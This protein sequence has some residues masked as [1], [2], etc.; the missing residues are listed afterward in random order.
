M[1]PSNATAADYEEVL[2]LA[3]IAIRE[4]DKFEARRLARRASRLEP[5]KEEPWLILAGL[6][7]PRPGLAYAARALEI[8]P[9]SKAAKKA[10]RWH[11][12]RLPP[13]EREEALKEAHIPEDLI[14]EIL[15][16]EA[17]AQNK[18]FSNRVIVSAAVIVVSLG[19][20]VGGF[21]ADALQPKASRDPLAKAT[22]TPTPTPTPTATPTP[23]PTSTPTQT[24]T[25]TPTRTPPVLSYLASYNIPEDELASEGRWIDVDLSEQ[26]VH[27]YEGDELVRS[28]TVSTGTS[29]HPT[30]TGQYRVYI[31]LT[32]TAM[33][34]PGYYL[35]GVPYTMYFY[36][37]YALHGTYWHDNFGVP[38]SHGCINMRTP[39]AEWLFNFSSLGI[40]VNIHL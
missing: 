32:S 28:F 35:P 37:G 22:L 3:K 7:D 5:T 13:R 26:K 12:R 40:L 36:K 18:L 27:A 14:P 10:I 2:R 25:V 20:W 1:P 29:R 21:P 15:P 11:V 6:S 17:L 38:M 19:L 16:L 33:A 9:K 34:G 39:E 23:T 31:K 8:N 24:P 30:V 4:G